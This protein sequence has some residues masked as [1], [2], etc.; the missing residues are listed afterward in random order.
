M[1][2]Q[3]PHDR[4]RL[5][6]DSQ[7][8]R[9][10][11]HRSAVHDGFVTLAHA[12]QV[13][14]PVLAPFRALSPVRNLVGD[15]PHGFA[16]RIDATAL[17]PP[18]PY[19]DKAATGTRLA[20]DCRIGGPDTVDEHRG[21]DRIL[22]RELLQDPSISDVGPFD[23]F[24]PCS[25]T[26]HRCSTPGGYGSS[27]IDKVA[28]SRRRIVSSGG[29]GS[30]LPWASYCCDFPN[31][32]SASSSP[33]AVE[34]RRY[35]E[36]AVVRATRHV[37][38][39]PVTFVALETPAACSTSRSTRSPGSTP[40]TLVCC[41]HRRQRTV[42]SSFTTVIDQ[43]LS[44]GQCVWI[45]NRRASVAPAS[46]RC[47]GSRTADLSTVMSNTGAA[48]SGPKRS[49]TGSFSYRTSGSPAISVHV[50][51]PLGRRRCGRGA[52]C[53]RC[54]FGDRCDRRGRDRWLRHLDR[55]RWRCR[56]WGSRHRRRSPEWCR[57][58]CRRWRDR[59]HVTQTD[60]QDAG[61]VPTP[62]PRPR[63]RSPSDVRQ[64]RRRDQTGLR[65][66]R[67]SRPTGRARRR[68]RSARTSR[69][70]LAEQFPRPAGRPMQPHADDAR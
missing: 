4:A 60:P 22:V 45:E 48:P 19:G 69:N 30:G 31:R 57:P 40:T 37:Q 32:R 41:P 21:D 53:R 9:R 13:D 52:R 34:V 70:L 17:G 25:V 26:E 16:E 23:Q 51:R 11:A 38:L 55:R 54:R 44:W 8:A 62:P 64:A 35:V 59:R 20:N 58:A 5:A 3:L 6:I 47:F 24:E 36:H 33:D 10:H 50:E 63:P 65:R 27:V 28:L 39:T 61:D 18:W 2:G 49:R 12:Q 67:R 42:P 7:Q 43:P 46:H 29:P 15:G 66:G 68:R 1:T 56:R 14:V